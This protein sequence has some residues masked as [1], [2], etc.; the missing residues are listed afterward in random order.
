M[1]APEQS[2]LVIVGAAR[3][4]GKTVGRQL[5]VFEKAFRLF[6]RTSYVVV[7]SD[8]A[9]NTVT[10]LARLKAASKSF[11]FISLGAL[12]LECPLRTQ[13]IARARTAALEF[14]K[15][16]PMLAD[17]DYVA[18]ADWDGVN[19]QLT[20]EAV[21][22]CW[23]MGDWDAVT[24]N[25]PGGYYD[26][27]ALRHETW[28]P[29]DCWEEYRKLSPEFGDEV[30]HQIAIAAKRIRIPKVCGVIDVDSAF[31]GLAIY[32]ASAFLGSHYDAPDEQGS[33]VCEHVGFHRR[34]KAEGARIIIN[35]ALVNIQSIDDMLPWYSS[36]RIGSA[37][38]RIVAGAKSGRSKR[39]DGTAGRLGKEQ[40]IV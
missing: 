40:P 38:R 25:Q 13:R 37:F 29:G 20:E 21:R 11:D 8:S 33:E 22:S 5:C 17:A 35:P 7:E 19:L 3:N 34:M 36:R 15:S 1:K 28:C 23:E 4:V 24:A 32:K 6:E 16:S 9:D 14:C 30:A 2:H 10:G 18:V 12:E 27:W 31:G 26:I 39:N